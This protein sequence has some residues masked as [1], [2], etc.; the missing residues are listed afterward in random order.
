LINNTFNKTLYTPLYVNNLKIAVLEFD[1]IRSAAIS[2]A[3]G[4]GGYLSEVF[5]SYRKLHNAFQASRFDVLIL[6]RQRGGQDIVQNVRDAK[7]MAQPGLPVLV[8]VYHADSEAV[9]RSLAA[10]ADDYLCLPLRPAELKTRVGVL[11]ARAYPERL[12]SERMIFGEFEFDAHANRV[13]CSGEPVKLTRR[14]FNLALLLF[15]HMGQPLSRATIGEAVWGE[16]SDV[17][18]RTVDTHISR[19]RTRLRLRPEQ[20]Y[21]IDQVYGYGYQL[22]RIE[23]RPGRAAA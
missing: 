1:R 2:R 4:S 8:L 19:L 23:A 11:I 16:G 13:A 6:G 20:G 12:A 5:A 18:S 22:T 9:T 14:E 15:T 7:N 10:G 21:R 3:L 17:L